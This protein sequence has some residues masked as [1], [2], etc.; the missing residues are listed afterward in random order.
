MKRHDF[1]HFLL[2]KPI[3]K[4]LELMKFQQPTEV[5]SKV[6]SRALNGEDLIVQSQTGSGKT[7]A[8][9]LPLTEKV[10]WTENKP[11]ALILTPTR[12]LAVQVRDE[13]T[14]I[15]RLKRINAVAVFGK[16]SYVKQKN[17]LKQKTHIVVGTPGRVLDHIQKG[18]L[19]VEDIKHLIIDEADQMLSMG[20]IEEM[21]AI[22]ESLPSKRQTMVFSATYPE[23][24]QK[25]CSTY[26][27]KPAIIEIQAEGITATKIEHFKIYVD[28]KQKRAVLKDVLITENPESCMIFCNTQVEVDKLYRILNQSIKSLGKLHGGMAQRDRFTMI[29]RFR[30]GQ[31]RYLVATGVAGR[32]IDVEKVSL[33]INFEVPMEAENYVHRTGRTGRAGEAG[34]AITF[35]SDAEQKDLDTIEQLIGF[36]IEEMPVPTEANVQKQRSKFQQKMNATVAPKVEKSAQ[37]KQEVTKLYFNGGKKK[38]LRAVDFVGTISKI[39]GINTDDIGVISIFDQM[40]YVDILNGKGLLVLQAMKERP[41]KGKQLKVHIARK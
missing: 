5:Q 23:D 32:G 29:D 30:S 9:A 3:L 16:D 6:V 39:P 14:N 33:V 8:F 17:L 24:I 11:Q 40:T 35:V 36:S 31:C 2:S 1:S 41:V 4:A 21:E 12:E 18:T 7:L 20:F 25:L 37:L 19:L 26:M 22:I 27:E 13:V 15:G 34:K 38:K 10:D 28:E